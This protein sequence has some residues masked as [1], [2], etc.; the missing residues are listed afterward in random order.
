MKNVVFCDVTTCGYYENEYFGG[1]YRL[2]HQ[3]EEKQLARKN[4]NSN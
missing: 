4:V 2:H 1:T 3:G